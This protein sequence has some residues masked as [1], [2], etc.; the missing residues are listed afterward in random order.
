MTCNKILIYTL[1][2]FWNKKWLI[3]ISLLILL[4]QDKIYKK[5]KIKVLCKSDKKDRT[6]SVYLIKTSLLILILKKNQTLK[7]VYLKNRRL[8]N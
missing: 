4:F 6:Q 3:I 5:Y 7:R 2:I 8:R 1:I